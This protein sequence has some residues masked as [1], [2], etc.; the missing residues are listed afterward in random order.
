M[1]IIFFLLQIFVFILYSSTSQTMLNYV[2]QLVHTCYVLGHVILPYKLYNS[3]GCCLL[4][5]QIFSVYLISFFLSSF[6][7]FSSLL[8]SFLPSF[9]CSKSHACQ[10]FKACTT[11]CELFLS[12]NISN[13]FK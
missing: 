8:L 7:P 11:A 12:P 3:Y 13:T 10:K 4:I 2:C 5:F 1:E 9:P 6:L